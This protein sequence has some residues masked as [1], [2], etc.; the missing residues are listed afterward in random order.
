MFKEDEVESNLS[1]NDVSPSNWPY[2]SGEPLDVEGFGNWLKALREEKKLTLAQLGELTGYSTPH[3]SQ[4]ETGKKKNMP[5]PDF[6]EKLSEPLHVPYSDLLYMAGYKDLAQGVRLR[7]AQE[8]FADTDNEYDLIELREQVK[9]I[10]GITDLKIF[11]ERE[12]S[13]YPMYNGHSL[14]NQDRQRVLIM[15]EQLFPEYQ[16][17]PSIKR[18]S[19]KPKNKP[20]ADPDRKPE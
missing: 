7:E 15:L 12:V 9:F 3:L 20:D 18:T 8:H 19:R 6:L 17:S 10:E 4:I 5:S 16:Q 1:R 11:L 14:T 2:V 13:P